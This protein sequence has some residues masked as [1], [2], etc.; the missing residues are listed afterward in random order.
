MEGN[1]RDHPLPYAN[2]WVRPCSSHDVAVGAVAKAE[3]ACE[4]PVHGTGR[5]DFCWMSIASHIVLAKP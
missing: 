2:S 5:I 4:L 3:H 1:K